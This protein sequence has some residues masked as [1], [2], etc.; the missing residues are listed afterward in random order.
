M[1][2]Q[3]KDEHIERLL[4]TEYTGDNLLSD[5]YVEPY[6]LP[7]LSFEDID[8]STMFMGKRVGFPLLIN[9]MTGGTDMSEAINQDLALLAEEF[10]LPMEVGSQK[11][12]LEDETSQES[13]RIVREQLPGENIVLS[14]IGAD[15]TVEMVQA[16]MDMIDA[17]GVGIHINPSQ[18]L[19]MEEGDTD[20]R[21]YLDNLKKISK[22]FPNRVI[23][24][25]IGFGM[26][27]EVGKLL[28]EAGIHM[29]DVSGAGGTNFVEIEDLRNIED[30]FTEFY[31][32]GIPTAVSIINV[33]EACPDSFIIA[34]GGIRNA[35]DI[36]KSIIIGAD[37]CGMSGELLRYLLVGGYDYARNFLSQLIHHMKIG[38]L[39]L[40]C[41]NLEELKRLDFKLTGELS[42]IINNEWRKG[43]K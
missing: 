4:K 24:K 25:E 28:T 12:A 20:F 9:A 34:S 38:M 3:R 14:N 10:G 39:L 23:A 36:L 40:G 6:S 13:F 19:V 7:E 17:D 15:A 8:T 30:D 42:E 29:I 16:V 32:W 41:K 18:E 1:R 27:A 21:G 31:N 43:R 33:R 2:K 22:A 37:F 35:T 5:V 26:R 11:I